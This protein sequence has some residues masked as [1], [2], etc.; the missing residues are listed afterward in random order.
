VRR[1]ALLLLAAGSVAC[2]GVGNQPPIFLTFNGADV[3]KDFW[4]VW[5]VDATFGFAP[6]DT[7]PFEVE[8]SDPEGQDVLL[9]WPKSPPGFDFPPDGRTGTWAVPD[10]FAAPWWTFT[11]IARDDGDEPEASVLTVDF[12]A[13]RDTGW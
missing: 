12:G 3:N 1:P 8:V 7:I 13:G 6:G 4:G 2:G 9:W 10:D 11:L 5:W